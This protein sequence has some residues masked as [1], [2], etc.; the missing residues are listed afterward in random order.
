MADMEIEDDMTGNFASFEVDTA[1]DNFGWKLLPYQNVKD[2]EGTRAHAWC[3]RVV[4]EYLSAQD[5]LKEYVPAIQKAVVDKDEGVLKLKMKHVK[6]VSLYEWVQSPELCSDADAAMT[7]SVRLVEFFSHLHKRY[8]ISHG[9]VKPDNI[10]IEEGTGKPWII[11]W[12]AARWGKSNTSKCEVLQGN[13]HCSGP[14]FLAVNCDRERPIEEREGATYDSIKND[15]FGLGVILTLIWTAVHSKGTAPMGPFGS[16][17][18]MGH[19]EDECL[20]E[21]ME[22]A[23][24]NREQAIIFLQQIGAQDE[25]DGVLQNVPDFWADWICHFCNF[26]E[27][28]RKDVYDCYKALHSGECNF[29]LRRK[30]MNAESF[31]APKNEKLAKK[32]A[33]IARYVENNDLQTHLKESTSA[34]SSSSSSS[35]SSSSK[36]DNQGVLSRPF[37]SKIFGDKLVGLLGGV[38][39]LDA[40]LNTVPSGA[41]VI[42]KFQFPAEDGLKKALNSGAGGKKPIKAKIETQTPRGKANNNKAPLGDISQHFTKDHVNSPFKAFVPPGHE[43]WNGSQPLSVDPKDK[44]AAQS[45]TGKKKSALKR[46]GTDVSISKGMNNLAMG[47]SARKKQKGITGKA[48]F[49]D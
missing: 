22:D 34:S 4:L 25:L 9:D 42:K 20:E 33:S 48:L 41:D 38:P 8:G 43:L 16:A 19:D 37:N 46:N 13:V 1:D 31:L 5:D 27:K 35:A 30:K 10:I 14:Q 3:E 18:D 7:I 45:G 17:W 21:L 6:G 12:G 39:E 26:E 24:C 15:V 28:D 2:D 36:A 44:K 23:E 49:D 29:K 32:R 40:S 47:E 11:D